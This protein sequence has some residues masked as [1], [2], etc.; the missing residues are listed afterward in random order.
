M[1]IRKITV[2]VLLLAVSAI[3]PGKSFSQ[4]TAQTKLPKNLFKTNPL[5]TLGGWVPLTYER[6]I[7]PNKSIVLGMS[8]I[9]NPYS[10]VLS[11]IGNDYPY[12]TRMGYYF[13]PAIRFYLYRLPNLP[14]GF[15]ASPEIGLIG[16]TK[17]LDGD[18]VHTQ[19][20]NGS[21]YKDSIVYYAPE[22]LSITEYQAAATIGYQSVIN[23]V[24]IV[25]VYVGEGMSLLYYASGN[26]NRFYE[27]INKATG[28][29]KK[30]PKDG[31]R[32]LA[33][34]KVGIPF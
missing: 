17:E 32:L 26:V 10:V 21:Y 6:F 5:Y 33:G 24:F 19:Y 8:Y 7:T 16:Q 9:T 14:G 3:L 20:N 29:N 34:F 27:H 12:K 13:N 1:N 25:D 30:V 22:K 4:D 31:A 2:A 15:Y 18:S 28:S 11:V 23:K